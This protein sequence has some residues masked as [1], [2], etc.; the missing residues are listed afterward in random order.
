MLGGFHLWF[1]S[2][3]FQPPLF[4][5]YGDLH[6]FFWS[7]I[8]VGNPAVYCETTLH[9]S[10]F[11]SDQDS[12]MPRVKQISRKQ[13]IVHGGGP[14]AILVSVNDGS[15]AASSCLQ[16]RSTFIYFLNWEKSLDKLA[17]QM[18]LSTWSFME[19]FCTHF[20]SYDFESRSQKRGSLAGSALGLALSQESWELKNEKRGGRSLF[21]LSKRINIAETNR[22][23]PVFQQI[24][25]TRKSNNHFKVPSQLKNWVLLL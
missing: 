8:R 20:C 4:F 24:L 11:L 1:S 7:A 15:K 23:L 10:T 25:Q 17:L 12:R 5:L 18:I 6:T 3:A 2:P 13:P 9:L 21:T 22:L 14:R 19:L 16:V